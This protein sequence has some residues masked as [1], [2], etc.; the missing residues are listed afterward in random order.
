M[1]FAL[2]VDRVGVLAHPDAP[3]P[4]SAA[5]AFEGF[6]VPAGARRARRVHPWLPRVP[7]PGDRHRRARA[8]PATRDRA[9]RG[10]GDRRGRVDRLTAAPAA[11]GRAAPARGRR[12]DGD[13]GDR[14][15]APRG[16][17]QAAHGPSTSR[18]PRWTS[19]PRRSTSRARTRWATGSP[20]GCASARATCCPS[21][22]RPTT[23]ICA[24]LPYVATGELDG[25]GR[26]TSSFEPRAAL[27]GGAGR[28]GRDPP[29]AGAAARGA[30]GDG[31][32]LLEIGA[33]QG[34]AIVAA[35][36]AILPGWR[37]S[38]MPDLA[39]CRGSRASSPP[40]SWSGR[41]AREGPSP[42]DPAGAAFP[43]RMLAL[44]IDGTLVGHDMLLSERITAPSARPCGA[45]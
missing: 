7:R 29:A 24:N 6:V 37:C 34:E 23:V 4:A 32:A 38:V 18:S 5:A 39:G 21:A 19:A 16:P 43:V 27:D 44:D 10:R 11:A 36:T 14:R 22:T 13:G 20:T 35:V 12:R 8:H 41:R 9:A 3:V 15:R 30:R 2:G 17:A 25:A 31:V 26:S 45:A 28:A 1:G 40:S 42:G 33:D